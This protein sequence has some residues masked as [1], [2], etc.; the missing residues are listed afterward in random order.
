MQ[1]ESTII[2]THF[3]FVCVCVYVC[4]Y[5]CMYVCIHVC[6]YVCMH[7]YAFAIYMP[8]YIYVNTVSQIPMP[9]MRLEGSRCSGFGPCCNLSELNLP[10]LGLV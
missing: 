5:V 9:G 8:I 7:A 3:V 1:A 10:M 4:M 2:Y 6:M